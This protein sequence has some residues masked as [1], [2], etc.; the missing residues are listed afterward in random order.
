[1]F[2]YAHALRSAVFVMLWSMFGQLAWAGDDHRHHN[3]DLNIIEVF[4]T[5]D[6][7]ARGGVDT[8]TVIGEDLDFGRSLTVTLGSFPY[9]LTI[10]DATDQQIVAECPTT[11]AGEVCPQGDHLLR[12]SGGKGKRKN[13]E[14]DL[15]IGGIG[16]AGP[17]GVRGE[18][19]PPGPQGAAGIA[20]LP[21]A[22]G[23]QGL[24][25]ADGPPGPPGPPGPRGLP[26]RAGLP[27]PAGP[28]GPPG[29]RGLPGRAGLPGPSGP[30]GAVEFQ[31]LLASPVSTTLQGITG[32]ENGSADVQT[33]TLPTGQWL[34]NTQVRV[35]ALS[36]FSDPANNQA[37]LCE[38]RNGV[39]IAFGQNI[40]TIAGGASQDPTY[41]TVFVQADTVV[42][43]GQT[44]TIN[45]RFIG[46]DSVVDQVNLLALGTRAL[47]I[48]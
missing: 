32:S 12:V 31:R 36:S 1:M 11:L 14:W 48:E 17:Q 35:V 25:G 29:P 37:V 19:G 41:R 33:L 43:G 16:P 9:P 44:I 30:P 20:G 21:G 18:P 13:D 46:F 40:E 22:Q 23:E 42:S 39:G 34:L 47:R 15:T 28:P 27:G 24:P 26:G 6:D 2:A 38:L 8:I 3:R 5:F 45:C 7:A 10:L 4:V